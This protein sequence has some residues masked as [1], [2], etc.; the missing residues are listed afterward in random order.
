MALISLDFIFDKFSCQFAG[1]HFKFSLLSSGMS[2]GQLSFEAWV[3]G[4]SV[5]SYI[6]AP[7]TATC[8]MRGEKGAFV[9]SYILAPSYSNMRNRGQ[10]RAKS[11]S[12][13]Y[14]IDERGREIYTISKGASNSCN[15]QTQI[16]PPKIELAVNLLLLLFILSC[17][18]CSEVLLHE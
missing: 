4:G 5:Q 1:D 7:L 17:N 13:E 11:Y 10:E 8:E 16:C 6:S 18:P 3:R 14:L 9:Q 2:S 12:N 15:F